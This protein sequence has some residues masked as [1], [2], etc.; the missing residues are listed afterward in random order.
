MLTMCDE[1]QPGRSRS[2]GLRPEILDAQ[3]TRLGLARIT[4]RCAW[5]GYDAAFGGALDQAAALGVTHVVFGDIL[6][7]EHREWAERICASRGLTAVEPLWGSSTDTLFEE[8]VASGDE[9]VIVTARAQF[10]DESWLGRVLSREM[11]TAF[12]AL[13]VDACGERG[14]YHTVVTNSS[15][16]PAPIRWRAGLRVRRA[17]CWALDVELAP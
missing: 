1:E 5:S 12:R 14:E 16:F 3:A 9:A 4:G 10:L 17:D 15:L 11:A 13:R 7:L 6:F 2:H 8:W